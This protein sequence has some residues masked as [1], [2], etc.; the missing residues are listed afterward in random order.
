MNEGDLERAIDAALRRRLSPPAPEALRRLADDAVARATRPARRR[1]VTGLAA[2]AALAAAALGAWMIVEVTVRRGREPYQPLPRQTLAAVYQAEVARG[3]VP[4]W[5]CESDR[6]IADTLED[7]F[8][9][10][11]HLCG[12]PSEV[13]ALGWCYANTLSPSSI[14]LLARAGGAPIVVFVDR[15]ERDRPPGEV[16]GDLRVHRRTV[17]GLVLYE[18]SS[19]QTPRVLEHFSVGPGEGCEP[20]S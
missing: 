13:E 3:L 14:H 11:L 4:G 1:W 20:E 16:P 19:L 9:R 15:I 5:R 7:R 18:V 10:A 12:L 17:G 6:E 2:A 8:G